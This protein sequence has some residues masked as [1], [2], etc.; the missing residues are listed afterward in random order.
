MGGAGGAVAE[1]E[2]IPNELPHLEPSR[3]LRAQDQPA[4]ATRLRSSKVM[5]R[6]RGV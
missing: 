1:V 6:W 2:P 3:Q 5:S 4:W